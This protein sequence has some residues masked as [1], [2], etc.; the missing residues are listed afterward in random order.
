MTMTMTDTPTLVLH[1]I[2]EAFLA[3]T[4]LTSL[5]S[6]GIDPFALNFALAGATSQAVEI[7]KTVK[8]R[9]PFIADPY[10][11][12]FHTELITKRSDYHIRPVPLIHLRVANIASY[13]IGIAT[14]PIRLC[15]RS[16]WFRE[17][18]YCFLC[19]TAICNEES[20]CSD[21]M[22]ESDHRCVGH[23][24]WRIFDI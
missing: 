19:C 15:S 6:T 18:D 2:N 16:A 7:G 10:V 5:A 23:I 13:L 22:D 17:V 3:T 21:C 8:L 4:Q 11:K 14:N 9:P 1:E 20:R 24:L 12:V